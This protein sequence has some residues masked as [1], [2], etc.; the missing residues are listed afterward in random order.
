MQRQL[1]IKQI[2]VATGIIQEDVKAMLTA[3]LEIIRE[4][5]KEGTEVCLH[6]F[7]TFKTKIRGAKVARNLKG[8]V[9]GKKKNPEP[10][11]LPATTIP[12]FKPS[13]TFLA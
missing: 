2:S 5:V 1:L 10:I 8:R 7:G 3:T 6:D 11:H 13:K 4:N 12:H 9:N